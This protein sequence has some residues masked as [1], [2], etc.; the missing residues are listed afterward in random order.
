MAQSFAAARFTGEALRDFYLGNLFP[1]IRYLNVISREQC[2]YEG[3]VA[4][5]IPLDSP[6]M[7]GVYYHSLVDESYSRFRETSGIYS[8]YPGGRLASVALRVAED[9][10]FYSKLEQIPELSQWLNYIPREA[11]EITKSPQAIQTWHRILQRYLKNPPGKKVLKMGAKLMDISPIKLE[12]S[13]KLYQQVAADNSV[14]E[15]LNLFIQNIENQSV[16]NGK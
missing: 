3:I 16:V 4:H 1:D 7:A 11:V 6:F 10:Y 9:R 2:H 8:D 13:E 14:K 15:K 12:Q 5:E